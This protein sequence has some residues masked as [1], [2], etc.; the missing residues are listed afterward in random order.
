MPFCFLVGFESVIGAVKAVL[1]ASPGTSL[2][3]TRRGVIRIQKRWLVVMVGGD[4]P[5]SF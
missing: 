2:E 3:A 1:V 4:K 5:W